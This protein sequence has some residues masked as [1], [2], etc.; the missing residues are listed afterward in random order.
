MPLTKE[1]L[2]R[3]R[4]TT[5]VESGSY[6]GEAVGFALN[7]GF[8]S[9]HTIELDSDRAA[10]VRAQFRH[11]PQVHVYRGDSSVVL[12]SVI[13]GL[14]GPLVI[15]LDA[16]PPDDIL[17]RDNTPVLSE[18][19]AVA[20]YAHRYPVVVLIDDMRLFSPDLKA[21]VLGLVASEFPAGYQVSYLD[22]HIA[23][24]DIM[25]VRVP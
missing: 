22:N 14:Q 21:E 2:G 16:H 25:L 19:S 12:P 11:S 10:G 6:Q 3:Y 5:L 9:V 4:G 7:L 24:A 15:W 8:L 13:L 17:T 23:S 20:S 1:I 18:L